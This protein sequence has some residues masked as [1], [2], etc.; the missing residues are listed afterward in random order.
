MLQAQALS[1]PKAR[2]RQQQLR[3]GEHRHD[4]DD[5]QGGTALP[6]VPGI[7]T[8][9]WTTTTAIPATQPIALRGNGFGT[10]RPCVP[11]L[12]RNATFW[13]RPSAMPTAAAPN[14]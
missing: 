7:G 14:P 10:V 8:I 11:R 9:T 6:V 5:R 13:A 2:S 3:D 1:S 12:R 4:P